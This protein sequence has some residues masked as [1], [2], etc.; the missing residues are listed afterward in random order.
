MAVELVKFIVSELVDK[1][2]SVVVTGKEDGD[3]EVIT[4]CVDDADT[5]KIIGKQ[6]RIAMAIRTVVKAV[7]AKNNKKYS[8]EIVDRL[9]DRQAED[10]QAE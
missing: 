7:G 1:P 6:G 2:E 8:V 3:T 9:E 10:R 5:G 4:V